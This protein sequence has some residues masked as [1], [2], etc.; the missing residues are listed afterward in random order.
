MGKALSEWKRKHQPEPDEEAELY[1]STLLYF[2]VIS[3][4]HPNTCAEFLH[5]GHTFPQGEAGP[6]GKPF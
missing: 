4:K 3:V 2:S 1:K 6:L 5:R